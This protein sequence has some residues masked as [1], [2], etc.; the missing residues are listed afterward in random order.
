M[1]KNVP[2]AVPSG[3]SGPPEPLAIGVSNEAFT[4]F[5]RTILWIAGMITVAWLVS[6]GFDPAPLADVVKKL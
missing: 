6:Q 1:S 5:M 2:P 4:Q 3:S